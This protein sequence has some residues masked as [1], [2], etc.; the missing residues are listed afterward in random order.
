MDNNITLAKEK[1]ET[2]SN[3]EKDKFEEIYRKMGDYVP[4]NPSLYRFASTGD[5]VL[6]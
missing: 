6:F 3:Q 5:M 2:E 4:K 1:S